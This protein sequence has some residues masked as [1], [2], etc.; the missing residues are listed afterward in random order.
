VVLNGS[1]AE[2]GADAGRLSAAYLGVDARGDGMAQ[3][4]AAVPDEH[5]L[6]TVELETLLVPITLR[7][8]RTLQVLADRAGE[9]VGALVGRLIA[10]H[11]VRERSQAADAGAEVSA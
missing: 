6:D 5:R 3:A 7:D 8:R 9:P 2:V 10:A 1:S 11:T 4:T